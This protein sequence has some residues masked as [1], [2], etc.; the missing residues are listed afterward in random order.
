MLQSLQDS[1]G[2]VFTPS[3]LIPLARI[4]GILVVGFLTLRLIDSALSRLRLIVP[5]G[6]MAAHP[7]M[8]QRA[9]TLRHIIRS[10]SKA[11]LFIVLILTVS[12]ELGFSI[13]PLLAGA[14]IA[15][16][17]IGFG[18]QSLVKDIIAGFFILFEDQYGVGDV[19]KIG[20]LSGMVERMSLRATV[21]RNLEG[22]VHVIPNGH[23][24]TVTVM[25]KEWAR[26]VVDITVSHR[27]NLDRVDA[28][29]SRIGARLA[30][31]MP[32]RVLEKP[33]VLGIEKMTED[34]V[35]LRVAVKTL[36]LKQWEV[37]REWRRRI[38]EEFDREG[39]ELPSKNTVI[40]LGD[41]LQKR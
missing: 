40:V 28:I 18:A 19:I 11:A 34:G 24:Q 39:V 10:V 22:Q 4:A 21:L 37:A 15:G 3:A 1:F 8:E 13:A 12:S 36:P 17:A 14:G 41:E 26:T 32:D 6:E 5:P 9:E 25:T 20:E 29:L 16:L 2:L 7:R 23:I 31:D 30:E 33:Q 35:T 27:E 38:K